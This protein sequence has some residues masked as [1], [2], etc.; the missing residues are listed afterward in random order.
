[1]TD[2]ELEAIRHRESDTATRWHIL[3]AQY[4]RVRLLKE[5]DRLRGEVERLRSM[6]RQRPAKRP[7]A[8]ID[9]FSVES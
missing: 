6:A 5:V 3:K 7:D 9:V 1:M 4:D 2:E 8:S